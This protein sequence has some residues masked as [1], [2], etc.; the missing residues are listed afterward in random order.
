MF[1]FD[2]GSVQLLEHIAP[3][4]TRTGGAIEYYRSGNRHCKSLH[5]DLHTILY[6]PTYKDVTVKVLSNNKFVQTT[7]SMGSVCHETS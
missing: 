3:L 6:D 7:I 5:Y 4:A 1:V 2:F